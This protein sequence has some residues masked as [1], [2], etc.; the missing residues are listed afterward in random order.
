MVNDVRAL[1]NKLTKLSKV[2]G[3]L[4]KGLRV[5]RIWCSYLMF[6]FY[7]ML[8][9]IFYEASHDHLV[10]IWLCTCTTQLH[11]ACEHVLDILQLSLQSLS[12]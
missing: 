2:D 3:I 9:S 10:Y 5:E 1:I 8:S 11:C 7:I 12:C 4:F 6:H